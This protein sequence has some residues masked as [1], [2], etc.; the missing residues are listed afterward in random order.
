MNF[1]CVTEAQ[2]QK[3][4]AVFIA[5][6]FK[7]EVTPGSALP[8]A[9][10]R[11][12]SH[13]VKK[14]EHWVKKGQFH[15]VSH[16]EGDLII[17]GLGERSS[18][19]EAEAER[20]GASLH[21]FLVK[22]NVEEAH[23]VWSSFSQ[24][25]QEKELAAFARGMILASYEVDTY[26]TGRKSN[27]TQPLQLQVA[28]A[29]DPERG[30][31][32]FRSGVIQGTATN[33]ARRLI[34][35]PANYMT[36]TVLA[37]EAVRLAEEYD[38]EI[39]VLD[40]D[41]IEAAGMHAL[42]A[43]AKGSEEPPRFIV[44]K[45]RGR[46]DSSEW[47]TAI[48]GKGLTYDSGGYSLKTREGM[49]TMKMDMGGAAAILG[50]MRIILEEK[51]EV[52]VAAIIPSTE[53]LVNGKAMKPGDVINSLGG[54]TIEVLNTDAEGRLI[55]ADGV[56][57][58][59]QLGAKSIIDV[60]TLTG[61]VVVALG[62]TATGAV[63][64]NDEFMSLVIKAG[65]NAGERVWAFPNDKAYREKVRKSDVADLNN[66]PGRQ[67]GSITAGLFIGEFAGDIPWVHLDIAGTCWREGK[68]PSCPRGGTGS[69]VRT[70]AEAVRLLGE[71]K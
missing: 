24:R 67:A 55:L 28:C 11:K 60:A 12:I 44:I 42:M 35:T 69:M 47:D 15:Y 9:I 65:E 30:R 21:Q 63:T 54:K 10:G 56:A 62:D 39:E 50:A 1:D 25:E 31:D 57:Y 7:D 53:N 4:S 8:E 37:E 45:H 20:T 17:A 43:V 66:S 19:S 29:G 51:P 22:E 18:W 34:N 3:D 61:A 23:L 49:K 68:T 6:V 71:K 46:P 33:E 64:N 13:F 14:H 48:V 5:G 26:K 70:V 16:E 27:R 59:K 58:A 36:P 32:V 40:E 38:A 2:Q 41:Q 52:N